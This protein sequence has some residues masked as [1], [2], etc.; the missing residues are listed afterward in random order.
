MDFDSDT[1]FE[2]RWFRD[3]WWSNYHELRRGSECVASL[4]VTVSSGI[5]ELGDQRYKLK[6]SRWPAFTLYCLYPRGQSSTTANRRGRGKRFRESR[7]SLRKNG[8]SPLCPKAPLS[9]AKASC[10]LSPGGQSGLSPFFRPTCIFVIPN[11]SGSALRD[12]PSR[13][14]RHS[15]RIDPPFKI[16]SQPFRLHGTPAPRLIR[17]NSRRRR[18]H[19]IHNSPL[20]LHRLLARK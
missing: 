15:L 14:H 20:R 5:A 6:R 9:L 10:S 3:H 11:Y 13:P 16:R 8:D 12:A 19:R 2:Y 4:Q 7:L 18:Q 1:A 17:Q